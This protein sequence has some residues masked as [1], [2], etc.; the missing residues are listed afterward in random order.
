MRQLLKMDWMSRE[1]RDVYMRGTVDEG[2]LSKAEAAAFELI[3][4][5]A[6]EVEEERRHL[7]R[8]RRM[9]G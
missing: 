3:Y 5:K 9:A 4:E 6:K 8:I 2:S 1:E 7:A